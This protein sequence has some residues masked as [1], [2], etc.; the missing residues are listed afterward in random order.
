M[1]EYKLDGK[2]KAFLFNFFL[3]R[4]PV[5]LF[6]AALLWI[7]SANI[8]KDGELNACPSADFLPYLLLI[9]GLILVIGMG[10]RHPM[11]T[12][13]KPNCGEG[14]IMGIDKI[15]LWDTLIVMLSAGWLIAVA[16][17]AVPKINQDVVVCATQVYNMTIAALVCGFIVCPIAAI[18]LVFG[19]ICCNIRC[20]KPCRP[21]EDA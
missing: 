10:L 16:V 18:Y 11:D 4:L 3:F 20:C 13:F 15:T 17:Y 12:T 9:G 14:K 2:I 7:G 1:A 8:P 5:T 6:G 19:R 21:G